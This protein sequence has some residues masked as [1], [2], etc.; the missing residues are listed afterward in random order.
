M[1]AANSMPGQLW[2]IL[3]AAVC[4]LLCGMCYD[5]FREI[6][7]HFRHR[8]AEI[9]LDSLFSVIVSALVFVLV[10]G[11]V[12]QRLRG[13]MLVTMAFAWLIWNISVGKCFRW[14][15]ERLFDGALRCAAFVF[16][17]FAALSTFFRFF[18]NR[19]AQ[20]SGISKKSQ[21]KQKK[22]FHFHLR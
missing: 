18:Y 21:K 19:R 11:A 2:A 3:C 17:R 15:L 5:I 6:R 4:G 9:L 22:S 12:Q 13:Y 16:R 1:I 7:W 8:W 10:T 20:K 14:L